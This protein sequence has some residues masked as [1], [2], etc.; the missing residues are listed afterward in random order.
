MGSEDSR[1]SWPPSSGPAVAAHAEAPFPQGLAARATAAASAAAGT[2]IATS[3]GPA[4]APA[5]RCPLPTAHCGS[6]DHSSPASV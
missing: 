6:R 4:P 3:L 1:A 5:N 2:V